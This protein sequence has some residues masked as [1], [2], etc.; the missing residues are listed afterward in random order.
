[1]FINRVR[2]EPTMAGILTGTDGTY[3]AEYYAAAKRNEEI[4]KVLI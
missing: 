3:T 4:L 2:M 1:M